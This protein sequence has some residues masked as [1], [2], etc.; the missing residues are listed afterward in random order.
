MTKVEVPVD[1]DLSSTS[2]RLKM[3]LSRGHF[4]R[5]GSNGAVL[6]VVCSAALAAVPAPAR[7][8]AAMAVL[9]DTQPL[10]NQKLEWP[11]LAG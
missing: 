9:A 3:V 7:S 6:R 8:S 10:R 4:K 5:G 1:N 11:N 2:A